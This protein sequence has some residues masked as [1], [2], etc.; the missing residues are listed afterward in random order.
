MDMCTTTSDHIS[1]AR[2]TAPQRT[3]RLLGNIDRLAKAHDKANKLA[4]A[5]AMAQANAL[6]LLPPTPAA[7]YSVL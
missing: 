4:Q 5:N 3:S 6:P 1:T 2:K 7:M